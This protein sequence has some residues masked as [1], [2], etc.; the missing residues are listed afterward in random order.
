MAYRLMGMPTA[1]AAVDCRLVGRSEPLLELSGHSHWVWKVRYSPAHDTLLASCSSDSTV[2]LWHTPRLA[3]AAKDGSA[4]AGAALPAAGAFAATP[5]SPTAMGAHSTDVE[6]RVHTYED[7]EDSVYCLAWSTL[8]PWLLASLSY[9]GR[10]V[11]NRV[12]KSVKYK[13]M[14]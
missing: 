3:A 5:G 4:V 12:P 10:M 1:A 6:G 7:H 2:N 11:I 13:V 8:D 14:I 9:D